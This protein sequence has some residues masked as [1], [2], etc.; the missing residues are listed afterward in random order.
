MSSENV[1]EPVWSSASSAALD[2]QGLLSA[3]VWPLVFIASLLLL[4][5]LGLPMVYS[6]TVHN[7][8]ARLFWNQ[9]VWL[10][11]ASVMAVG[12]S[13]LPFRFLVRYSF[14]GLLLVSGLLFYLALAWLTNKLYP[15]SLH[16]FPFCSEIKGAVRWLRLS[17]GSHVWQ[18]QPS[19]FAKVFLLL[20]LAS[21]YGTL[22]R[23]EI[24][25]LTA[26][27]LL[28]G[29]TVG[30]VLFLILLGKDLS[31]T[32]I[33]GATCLAMMFYAGARIP[34]L[35]LIV[36][37]GLLVGTAAI[38]MSPE[39]QSRMTSYKNPEAEQL[40][41]AFQLWRSQLGMGGGGLKGRGF[42]K[43]VI[44]TFLPEAHTDFIVAVIGEELGFLGVSLVFF[45][46]L[47]LSTSIV[48]I[49]RQCRGRPE[50]LLCLGI[51]T[52]FCMQALINIG[53]VSGWCPTTG[54]TAPFLSYGG[55]SLMVLLICSALVIKVSMRNLYLIW[56]EITESQW[57]LTYKASD[58]IKAKRS[59]RQGSH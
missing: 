54:V 7:Y 14:W 19:E 32:V 10:I 44:K 46:Y 17:I 49:A 20:F 41:D 26:G 3:R 6:A 51:A 47:S 4:I 23:K 48:F 25:R 34:Y 57:H 43:G 15:G 27:I 22:P 8:E 28:P 31:S 24:K 56:Q 9:I 53:V 5:G 1:V 33:T 2:L 35:L 50:M 13:L 21:Y 18:I 45:L 29:C 55:S 37:L 36:A 40:G 12:V 39:R 11:I 38:K 30:A 59:V 16:Y 42:S 58:S 52:L